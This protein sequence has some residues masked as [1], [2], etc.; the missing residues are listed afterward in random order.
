[1][2]QA[3]VIELCK[4]GYRIRKIASNMRRK[5]KWKSQLNTRPYIFLCS[6]LYSLARRRKMALSEAPQVPACSS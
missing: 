6:Y 1:M 4:K 2:I 5:R 3:E